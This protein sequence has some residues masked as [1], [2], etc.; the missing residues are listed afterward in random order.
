MPEETTRRRGNRERV[1]E[2]TGR[3]NK[4]RERGLHFPGG[5]KP[6]HDSG[7]WQPVFAKMNPKI[8]KCLR[9]IDEFHLRRLVL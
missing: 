3:G 7:S 9:G 1:R 6:D 4:N 2:E 5:C 8:P